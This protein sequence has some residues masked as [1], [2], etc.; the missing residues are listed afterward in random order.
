MQAVLLGAL[1]V[2]LAVSSASA[3]PAGGTPAAL[4]TAERSNEVF[5]VS[6][7]GGRI[8]R[9]VHIADPQAVAAGTVGPAVVVNPAGTVTLLDWRTLRPIAV[10]RDFRSPQIAAVTPDS[11]WAYV[12]DAATGDLSVIEFHKRRVVSRVFVGYGAHHLAISPD[13]RRAWVALGENAHTLVVLDTS[14]HVDK[15]RVIGRIHPP[16][17]AH[18]LAFAPDG[19]TVWV[20]SASNPYVSVLNAR[21]GRLVATVPAGPPPQ[22]VAFIPY[23][24]PHAYIT[25][26][27]G[28]Q[29]EMVDPN[30]RKVL[31]RARVPYGSFNLATSGDLVVTSS[32]LDGEVT[33]L[34]GTNLSRWMTVKL[35]PL[36]RDAAISVW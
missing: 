15:P 8:V 34:D 28:S 11:E 13:L 1:V 22:H 12:T 33:E 2:P 31:R 23:G 18:D 5:A 14:Q 19:K 29:I 16:V 20:T 9:R 35:V 17:A 4:V 32:L 3:R 36:A 21:T 30:T 26:G 25:S 6:L 27:Y 7:P 24:K 10:L